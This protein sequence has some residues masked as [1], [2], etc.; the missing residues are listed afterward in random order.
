MNI[1]TSLLH[2]EG[3]DLEAAWGDGG[4]MLMDTAAEYR[5][6]PMHFG[7]EMLAQAQNKSMHKLN[8]SADRVRA[9]SRSHPPLS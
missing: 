6:N 8:T 3:G 1:L 4:H 5:M 2:D 9:T 7:L